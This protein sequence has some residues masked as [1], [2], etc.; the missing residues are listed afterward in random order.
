MIKKIFLYGTNVA[1]PTYHSKLQTIPPQC[2]RGKIKNTEY[3][4]N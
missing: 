1:V 3:F 4:N 2:T